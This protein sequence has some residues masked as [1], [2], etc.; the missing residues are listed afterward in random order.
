[1]WGNVGI[2]YLGLQIVWFGFGYSVECFV[3]LVIEIEFSQ[4]IIDFECFVYQGCGL[5]CIDFWGRLD[6]CQFF[7]K[8]CQGLEDVCFFFFNEIQIGI[9]YG[10]LDFY[11]FFCVYQ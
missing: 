10:V 11:M 3:F 6:M 1:M 9:E 7:I 2:C 5:Y 4:V 8:Y